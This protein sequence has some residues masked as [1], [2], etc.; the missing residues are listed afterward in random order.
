MKTGIHPNY[1]T[2][3]K[4]TCNSCKTVHVVGSTADDVDIEVC[5]NCHP[6]YTGKQN[7]LVDTDDR[8]S[9]FQKKLAS[10]DSTKV[11]KKRKKRVA[12]S[13]KVTEIGTGPKL[14]LQDMLKQ[15][16]KA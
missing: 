7:V 10:A 2:Q 15:A 5:A 1:N 4:I 3:T 13:T 11:V 14:T 16:S 8:I 9:K 12:R 6:F